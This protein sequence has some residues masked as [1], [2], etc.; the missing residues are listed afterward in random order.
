MALN[1]YLECD[2]C[3]KR[4][5]FVAPD[6]DLSDGEPARKGWVFFTASIEPHKSVA[7]KDVL[8]FCSAEHLEAWQAERNQ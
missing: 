7:D 3:G 4:E 8:H 1:Y 5:M 6:I 2:Y